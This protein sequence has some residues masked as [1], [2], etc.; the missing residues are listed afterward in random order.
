MK[1]IKLI[2]IISS[3]I[4]VLILLTNT[5]VLRLT[6][7]NILESTG[8]LFRTV[9]GL[10]NENKTIEFESKDYD[11]PGSWKITENVKWI[12]SNK[13]EITYNLTSV[14]ETYNK[15]KD[16]ILMIDTSGS[17]FGDKLQ[18]LKD[19]SIELLD[20]LL[21]VETNKIAL[22]EFNTTSNIIQEFTNDKETLEAKINS[23]TA[24]GV[25]NYNQALQ[26]LGTILET[27]NKE[28]NRDLIV[29]FLT[30]GYPVEENPSQK[31]TYQILKSK[32]DYLEIYGIQYE[33]GE[34]LKQEVKDITDRQYTANTSNLKNVLLEVLVS[35]KTYD[36]FKIEKT[37]SDYFEIINVTTT[38]GQAEIN[39]TN[40]KVTIDMN[41]SYMTGKEETIKV[42][43]QLKE[44]YQTQINTYKVN[45]NL[46][47][48]YKISETQEEYQST[49]TPV[50]SNAYEVTYELN[51]PGGCNIEEIE[52]TKHF[53]YSNVEISQNNLS[54]EG[55]LFKGFKIINNNITKINDN[56]FI[57]PG[58]DVTISAEWTK[59]SL[60]KTMDGTIKEKTTLYQAIAD[61]ENI[62]TKKYAGEHKDSFTQTA[63][64]DIYHFYAE[65]DTEA[66]LI[67]NSNNVIF[68]NHCWQII[69]TTDTGG[70]KLIYN[71]E[72][73]SDGKC[74]PDRG[75][76]VGYAS[77]TDQTLNSNYYYG[78]SY[79]YDASTK[80][81]ILSGEIEQ[82]TWND[83][84]AS[85]LIGKYTCKSS[86]E[87]GTCSTLYLI[88]SYNSSTQANVIP[89]NSN[90]N[91]SLFGTLQFNASR[92]SLAYVGYMYGTPYTY[93]QTDGTKTETFTKTETLLSNSSLN[94][95]YYYSDTIDSGTQNSSKYT[96]INPYLVSSTDDYPNLIGKYTFR[97]TSSSY[98]N[99]SVYYI[100]YINGSTMYYKQLSNGQTLD[101]ISPISFGESITDNGD[102]TYTLESVNT[103]EYKDW[104]TNYSTYKGKYTCNNNSITCTNPR[105][106]TATTKTNYT[107]VDASEKILIAKTRNGT[108]L[109]N[110][111]L[112]SKDELLKN[113]TNYNEYKYTCNS[114]LETCTEE[115]LRMIIALSATRY[116]YAVNHYFGTS[117]TYENGKYNL[118]NPLEIESATNLNDISTHH[119][120]CVSPGQKECSTVAYVYYYTGSG[121]MYYIT[122]KDGETS[123]NTALDKMLN[124]NTTSSTIKV[125][126]E[127]WYERNLLN[128]SSYIEDTIY[129]NDRSYKNF[130]SS[131]WNENG[132]N[133][134]TS[135]QF[136]EYS[137][138]SDLS[139][140][141]QTDQFSTSNESAKLKYPIGLATSP[142]MNILNN[143]TVRKTGQWYWLASPYSSSNTF[144][145]GIDVSYLGR[146]SNSTVDSDSVVGVRPAVSL[147]S[148]IEY[149]SGDGSTDNPY[150][151]E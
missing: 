20:T 100:A 67:L 125:G 137:V 35:P 24:N 4:I 68:A 81:F 40:T 78:T 86:T 37:I 147:I 139:C 106:V 116:T 98:T 140:T 6:N 39:E 120:I 62:L 47:V 126:L 63:T 75:T 90:S 41:K 104:Y 26:N 33:M 71:G 8:K 50:I 9:L 136:K 95:T 51:T 11:E 89:L 43:G 23:L 53:V 54:C 134:K 5:I 79:N 66:N 52:T 21:E 141:K 76:H 19:N 36:E 105:Y 30:D 59:L 34:T 65:N 7:K 49:N 80:T 15:N 150:V 2:S 149:A 142:E 124:Q 91:Y 74:G 55:Y 84:T 97:N 60:S 111:L 77:R 145:S 146:F 82:K 44:E 25:T 143:A 72:P 114:S 138:T 99:S 127:A 93:S 103:I 31:A 28:S 151:V 69:R 13:L 112:I 123:V 27:Y 64:H 113:Y 96:L 102:G 122:L 1:K 17:M 46:K 73:D 85:S 14:I 117:V 144:S 148:D 12:D 45:N 107:Y 92:N 115:T 22:I 70:V 18:T 88:E 130:E 16:V 58:E 57:M 83:S 94:T 133:T 108:T 32:Y 3:I 131:G 56:V 118:V 119:Y 109:S 38:V 10:S 61:Q 48:N 132:G 121:T 87:D 135:L 129:C 42:I 110:T 29:M 101:E 128:Y